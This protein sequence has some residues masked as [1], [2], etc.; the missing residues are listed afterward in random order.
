H[1]VRAARF[2]GGD[3][4]MLID[5]LLREFT[6]QK[7]LGFRL[8]EPMPDAKD[9][10]TLAYGWERARHTAPLGHLALDRGGG[11]FARDDEAYRALADQ[12]TA[13]TVAL[14]D[15]ELLTLLAELRNDEHE[16]AELAEPFLD[17]MRIVGT[18]K[19]RFPAVPGFARKVLAESLGGETF[20]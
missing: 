20:H 16:G 17:A 4:S 2:A 1:L 5:V 13:R 12:V 15:P 18:D 19:S 10:E 9:T 14:G 3:D 6:V 11:A 7:F 8:P